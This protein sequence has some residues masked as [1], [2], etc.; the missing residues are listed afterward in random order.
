MRRAAIVLAGLWLAA[1]ASAPLQPPG[2]GPPLPPR[3][4]GAYEESAP[5]ATEIDRGL[6]S[7]YGKEFHG[8]RTASGERFD[9]HELTA[10]H[11]RLP[12]GT[13]VRVTNVKNGNSVVV[14][15]NDR[16]PLKGKRVIDVSLEA[17][18][19]LDFVRDGLT[20]VIVEELH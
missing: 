14:W 8:R 19:Q 17:A 9:M 3:A 10:A 13:R 4:P 6:A 2:L 5:R 20:E 18:R 7:Y 12:F 1:C 15:V 16:G 11:P